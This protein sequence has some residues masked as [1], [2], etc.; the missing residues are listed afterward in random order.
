MCNSPY[1][2]NYKI[3]AHEPPPT[4][5][6]STRGAQSGHIRFLSWVSLLA[7]LLLNPVLGIDLQKQR[8]EHH[9]H[10]HERLRRQY[11]AV[12][13]ARQQNAEHGTCHH[14]GGKDERAKLRYRE[15]DEHLSCHRRQRDD[16]DVRRERRMLEH[17][18]HRICHPSTDEQRH[19]GEETRK[20]VHVEHHLHGGHFVLFEQVRLP[21]RSEAVECHIPNHEH[22]TGHGRLPGIVF[23]RAGSRQEKGHSD[24]D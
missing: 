9:N 7:L 2:T 8:H 10:A 21:V 11:V 4:T 23:V 12:D 3:Y 22:Q 19:R 15:K 1:K 24:R 16:K 18:G 13:D 6:H 17:K 5:T 14:D 20:T